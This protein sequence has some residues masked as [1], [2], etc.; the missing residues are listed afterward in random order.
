ML[1]FY[2]PESPVFLVKQD[3]LSVSLELIMS[4]DSVE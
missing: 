2:F 4:L 3:K 1:L